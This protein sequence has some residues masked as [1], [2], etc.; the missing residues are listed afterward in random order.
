[1]NKRLAVAGALLV[2]MLS[3]TGLCTAAAASA[4]HPRTLKYRVVRH[5]RAYDVTRGYHRVLRVA[6]RE[7]FVAVRGVP[8]FRVVRRTHRYVFLRRASRAVVRASTN[9]VI[10]AGTPVSV[11]L[12]ASASSAREGTSAGAGNDGA[13]ATRWSASS[14]GYPQWW[15]VDS[16]P[17]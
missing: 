8:R 6:H 13:A 12:P 4:S 17:R 14:R 1:M 7:R 15:M 3:T 10:A 11:G 2:L 5:T 16:G 9:G